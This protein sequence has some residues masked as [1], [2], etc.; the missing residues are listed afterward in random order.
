[1]K[2]FGTDPYDPNARS[3]L[4]RRAE[5][6]SVNMSEVKEVRFEGINITREGVKVIKQPLHHQPR[7]ENPEKSDKQAAKK[8]ELKLLKDD[9]PC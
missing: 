6:A 2:V 4:I 3:E 7:V 9:I 5:K 8:K 1:M